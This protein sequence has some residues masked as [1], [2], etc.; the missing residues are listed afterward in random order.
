[1]LGNNPQFRP[2]AHESVSVW[3]YMDFTKFVDL[4]DTKTL[5]FTRADR[6]DDRFEGSYPQQ[7]VTT[8]AGS[9]V[10]RGFSRDNAQGTATLITNFGKEMPRFVAINCWHI[11]TH[12]SAAMWRLYLKSNEGIA[13]QSTFQC[14][15]DSFLP[16]QEMIH[17]G[18][19]DYIDYESDKISEYNQLS[20][21]V[22]KRK[23]F[24]HEN[25]LRAIIF[26]PPVTG[27]NHTARLDIDVISDGLRVPVDLG[28]LILKVFVAPNSAAWLTKLVKSVATKY[29]IQSPVI[30]SSLAKD[31]VY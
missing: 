22:Y 14:L 23:S 3:R 4:L 17:L 28:K 21:F 1:M 5:F 12:E 20:P 11:N 27:A 8:R 13:I 25:E 19:V 29:G 6:F 30:Q 7:N 18:L 15:R 9:F 24:A 16:S 26:K 2:P 31:P 10:K